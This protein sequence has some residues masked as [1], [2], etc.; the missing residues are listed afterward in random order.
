MDT[1]ATQTQVLVT[2]L[3]HCEPEHKT[4]NQERPWSLDICLLADMQREGL[5]HTSHAVTTTQLQL[6]WY[7]NPAI[8][9]LSFITSKLH[10]KIAH[11]YFPIT[12]YNLFY[13]LRYDIV[14]LL[15]SIQKT[16]RIVQHEVDG[17]Q[18]HWLKVQ[19]PGPEATTD[20]TN[21]RCHSKIANQ[22][23]WS[24][25]YYCKFK[26]WSAAHCIA[27]D[28]ITATITCLSFSFTGTQRMRAL[29]GSETWC[30]VDDANLF[31][32]YQARQREATKASV[33][34]MA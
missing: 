14:I 1:G 31:Q 3:A 10:F 30:R 13:R 8:T 4:S 20:H 22:S 11:N 24:L 21:A 5:S 19:P 7:Y 23:V 9:D 6:Y 17:Y 15:D 18:L 28:S 33:A 2:N 29:K 12:F 32:D 25:F 26:R 27:I 34:A 16:I